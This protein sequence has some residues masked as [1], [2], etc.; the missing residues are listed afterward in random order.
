MSWC[1]EKMLIRCSKE[2]QHPAGWTPGPLVDHQENEKDTT[3]TAI[4]LGVKIMQLCS[5]SSSLTQQILLKKSSCVF[6]IAC[7]YYHCVGMYPANIC[8][9]L[10]E[11]VYENATQGHGACDQDFGNEDFGPAMFLVSSRN[12]SEEILCCF[13]V[14]F[15][16]FLNQI[17]YCT[18]ILMY[19]CGIVNRAKINK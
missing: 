4:S 8:I 17:Y 18:V 6:I 12:C 10:H 1:P 19:A 9:F 13:F 15:F 16:C 7:V 5:I 14:G 2:S 3:L 11:H